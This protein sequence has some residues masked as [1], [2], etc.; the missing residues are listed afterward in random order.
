MKVRILSDL[1]LSQNSYFELTDKDIFTIIAGDISKDIFQLKSWLKQ[2]VKNGLFI[3]GNHDFTGNMNMKDAYFQLKEEFPVTENLAFLQ[4]SYKEIDKKI[5]VGAT[6]WTDLELKINNPIFE[7]NKSTNHLHSYI[8]GNFSKDQKLSPDITIR[9]FNKSLNYIDFLCKEN[10]TK[11]IV[12]ITH[13]C[14]S[15]KCSAEKFIHNIMNPVLISNLEDF[16]INRKNIKYWICG[17]CHRDPIQFE[18]GQCKVL[19]NTRGYCKFNECPSF[20]EDFI[21]EM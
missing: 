12:V 9:E 14:P 5:F 16:I 3:L 17:H 21:V 6:L 4:N 20:K 15:I 19:M 1:H 2:N 8:R 10:P 11:D 13:H 7:P 18:I